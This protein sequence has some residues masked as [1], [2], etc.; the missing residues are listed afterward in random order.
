[1]PKL[2]PDPQDPLVLVGVSLPARDA[3][4]IRHMATCFAEEYLR[5][6]FDPEKV[7]DIFQDPFYAGAHE[8]YKALGPDDIR[9]VVEEAAKIWGPRPPGLYEES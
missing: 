2:E 1:M 5:M 6:G 3:S 8:A 4:A 9:S 7:M